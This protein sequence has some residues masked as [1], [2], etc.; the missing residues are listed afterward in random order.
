MSSV[1]RG[2]KA[3]VGAQHNINCRVFFFFGSFH[4]IN[5]RLYSNSKSETGEN[6][7]VALE[8]PVRVKTRAI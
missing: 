6:K 5:V 8:V 1:A 4:N 7:R 2:Y 3:W